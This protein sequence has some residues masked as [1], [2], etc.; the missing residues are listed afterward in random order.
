[1]TIDVWQM[2]F[3]LSRERPSNLNDFWSPSVT[4][5]IKGFGMIAGDI[6]GTISKAVERHA[7][8]LMSI[9]EQRASSNLEKSVHRTWFHVSRFI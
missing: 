2:R 5:E 9:S 6:T 3:A 8:I 1:V 4:D 7:F